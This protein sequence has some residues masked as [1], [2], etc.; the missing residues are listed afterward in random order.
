MALKLHSAAFDAGQSIPTR[1]TCDGDNISP[2]LSWQVMPDGTQSLALICDDPDAPSGTFSHWVLYNLPAG[3]QSL[4]ENY[5][6]GEQ[7]APGGMQ[8]PNDFGHVEYGGPCPPG[9]PPHHYHFRLYALDSKLN[10]S[11]G[12]T[13]DQVLGTIEPHVLEQTELVGIYQRQ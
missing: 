13:R 6:S 7:P 8:G 4:P 5:P 1:Y 10:L 9:G 3:T 12:A 11:P 2:P